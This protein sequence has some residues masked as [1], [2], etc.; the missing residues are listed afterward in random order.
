MGISVYVVSFAA[1][2]SIPKTVFHFVIDRARL[3][4]L[5]GVGRLQAA[6]HGVIDLPKP[7]AVHSTA[8][9]LRP[10]SR[11]TRLRLLR[12]RRPR[13]QR[14]KMKKLMTCPYF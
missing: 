14:Q 7:A 6:Q 8:Q 1:N 9:R 10:R 2:S 3:L 4:R 13:W 11:P 12:Q 5:Q